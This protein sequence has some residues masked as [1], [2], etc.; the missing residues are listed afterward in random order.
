M[1]FLSGL[2]KG[3]HRAFDGNSLAVTQ[4]ILAGDYQ[5]AAAIRARQEQ[6]QRSDAARDA[7]VR[8]AKNLGLSWDEIDATNRDDLSMLARQRA[9]LRM[10]DPEAYGAMEGAVAD[11]KPLP[12]AD[13]AGPL[14]APPP[15][16]PQRSPSILLA[17]GRLGGS[18]GFGSDAPQPAG[19]LQAAALPGARFVQ[20]AALGSLPRARTH[21][22]ASALP[23]G[24]YFLAP[25]ASLR[26]II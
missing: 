18:P 26:R 7:Q 25:D 1:S 20:T 3:L 6:L 12:P 8:A 19:D 17:S 24:S 13:E 16:R 21:A 2:A 10:V 22:E 5:T 9:A 23:K 11:D 4:A 15:G 14:Y